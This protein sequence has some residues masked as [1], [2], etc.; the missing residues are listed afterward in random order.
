MRLIRQALLLTF[1]ERRPPIAVFRKTLHMHE[2]HTSPPPKGQSLQDPFLNAL[3]RERIPVTIGLVN[4]IKV[5]GVIES[6][7]ANCLLI[8]DTG[9]DP[10]P[11]VFKHAIATISPSKPVHVGPGGGYVKTA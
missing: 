6:F 10:S 11:L 3:R 9:A 1:A 5:T 7:D 8:R 4:G 2:S